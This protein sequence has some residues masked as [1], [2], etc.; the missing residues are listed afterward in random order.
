LDFDRKNSSRRSWDNRI[1]AF[2]SKLSHEKLIKHTHDI[3]GYIEYARRLMLRDGLDSDAF[4]E[5]ILL[6]F[7]LTCD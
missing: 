2:I 6:L 5:Q 7:D 4:R 3:L 1:I